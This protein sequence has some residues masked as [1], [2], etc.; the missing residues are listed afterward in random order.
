MNEQFKLLIY[1]YKWTIIPYLC[2]C[3]YNAYAITD[4]YNHPLY[5]YHVSKYLRN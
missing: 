1:K 2:I 3:A 4:N 5:R